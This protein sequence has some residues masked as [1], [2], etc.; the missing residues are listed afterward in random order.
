V[1]SLWSPGS[2][3]LKLGL[4]LFVIVAGAMAI[5]YFAIVPRLETRLVN[6]TYDSL[7]RSVPTVAIG[8]GSNDRVYYPRVAD[9]FQN[10]LNA[11]VAVFER[12]SEDTLV[13]VADSYEA[14][15]ELAENAILLEAASTE[16][17]VR[18]RR[19]VNGREFAEVAAPVP[20]VPGTYVLLSAPLA[21]RLSAI[22]VVRRDLLIFGGLALATCWLVGVLA[23][24]RLT[25]RIR[26]L[27][28]ATE[29]IAAGNFDTPIVAE[30]NDEVAELARG[31]DRM[32]VRLAQLDRARRE[33]IGN[34]SHELRTPL[35]ALGGFL[36]LLADEDLDEATRRDFLESARG[37]VERLTR[38]ATDLLDLSRL[39]ADHAGFGS[40]PVDLTS[41]AE[42]LAD[43]FA[44]LAEATG[45][46]LRTIPG[47]RVVGLA[48]AERVLRIGRSLVEN[49]L[50]HTPA[51]TSVEVR[52]SIWVDRA[53][54][55]VHDD[56]PGIAPVD[57]E[58]VFERFY[59]GD[60]SAAEGSGIGLAIA[61]E[62]AQRMNGT[63]ELRS[64]PGSTTFTLVLAR[65]A[66]G[67]FPRENV[68][69]AKP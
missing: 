30:G 20:D 48:D 50:R 62:L 66:E 10:Q 26:R 17:L 5:V 45:H 51:G 54:L 7:R 16:S 40:E 39:D 3:G 14:P 33:F 35:F 38:L 56:G 41:I 64:E 2:L 29:R 22:N 65:A 67:A 13:L 37:Q 4:V 6:T 60:R 12:L 11:R 27:E 18:G 9:T 31:L 43:E 61:R 59:R 1:R 47:T 52:A 15:A 46:E 32:R 63:I 19:E 21:D 53:Q 25:R 42:T 24:L 28:S 23:A 44:A 68:L 8:L 58:R 69:V 55:S 57:Q 36:E 34:A 49:A